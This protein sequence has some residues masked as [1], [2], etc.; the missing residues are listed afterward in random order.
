MVDARG[1]ADEGRGE[2][3]RAESTCRTV[4]DPD[5][6]GANPTRRYGSAGSRSLAR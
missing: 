1:E 6:I 4:E 2:E 5:A 3:D